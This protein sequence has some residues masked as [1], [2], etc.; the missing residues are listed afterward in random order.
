MRDTTRIRKILPVDLLLEGRRCLVVGGGPIAARKIG[1]LL[2]AGARVTVVAR[3][4]VPEVRAYARSPRVTR[5]SREF[6][7]ADLKAAFLV[8]AATNDGSVNGRVIAEARRRGV[9]CCSVDAHWTRADFVTPATLRRPELTL[10]V[11]TGG[12][13]CRRARLVKDLLA[14]RLDQV[15]TADLA[16]FS[17]ARRFRPAAVAAT[18]ALLRQV[19]GVHEFALVAAPGGC[20]ALAVIARDPAAERL[21]KSILCRGAG[22]DARVAVRRGPSVVAGVA[23]LWATDRDRL[24]RAVEH[25]RGA[26][27]AGVVLGEWMMAAWQMAEDMDAEGRLSRRASGRAGT[28]AR[29]REH[30]ERMVR[31]YQGRD[32]VE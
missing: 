9:L 26:G 28:A 23:R 22:S 12:E 20:R 7:P 27:W 18:G 21:V 4:V 29:C 6:R 5:V 11:A 10:T 14:R 19:W 25:A 2:E 24:G 17:V 3:D 32:A 31:A 13:S 8:F 1:H 30:Y 16:V 15:V